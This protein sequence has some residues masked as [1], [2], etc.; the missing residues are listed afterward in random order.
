MQYTY[1]NSVLNIVDKEMLGVRNSMPARVISYNHIKQS[2]SALPLIKDIDLEG[3]VVELPVIDNI[4]VRFPASDFGGGK[5]LISFPVKAG[6]T[7]N[8]IFSTLS[9]DDW[10]NGD[11]GVVTPE[12]KRRLDL[13]DCYAEIGACTFVSNLRPHKDNLEIRFSDCIISIAPN[14]QITITSPSKVTINAPTTQFNGNVKIS[15]NLEVGGDI[16]SGGDVVAGTVSLQNH[17]NGGYPVDG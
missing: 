5:A 4:P 11:G 17:T 2:I 15:G 16:K 7:V 10:L 9:L 3:E 14:K 8:L 12:S 6:D 1:L 13:N